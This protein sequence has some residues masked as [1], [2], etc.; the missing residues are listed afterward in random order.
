MDDQTANS[1]APP[2]AVSSATAPSKQKLK[3]EETNEGSIKETIESILI[4]FILA[5]IFRGFVVEA[6]VIPTGSM[7]PTLLG[8]HMRFRCP[9]CGYEFDTNF[10]VNS[11]GSN[12]DLDIPKTGGRHENIFCPNCGYH[13]PAADVKDPAYN[14]LVRYGD[15]IL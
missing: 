15:R 7:A 13:L 6:F 11:S 14:P 8:A 10:N 2:P 1:T 5:F 3:T 12:D 4:A 9:D